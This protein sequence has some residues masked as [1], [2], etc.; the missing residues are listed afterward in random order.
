MH[1][2]ASAGITAADQH[3]SKSKSLKQFQA[4]SLYTERARF[5]DAVHRVVDQAELHAKAGK[6]GRERKPGRAG[7]HDQHVEH[8]PVH[9]VFTPA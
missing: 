4:T 9:L 6:P 1:D 8:G 5:M 3:L 2:K 7:T